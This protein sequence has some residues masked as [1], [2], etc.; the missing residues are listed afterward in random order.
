MTSGKVGPAKSR[1]KIEESGLE[2]SNEEHDL[3]DA[4]SNAHFGDAEKVATRKA[5][6]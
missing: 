4:P 3:P 2:A 1:V 6:L 5:T